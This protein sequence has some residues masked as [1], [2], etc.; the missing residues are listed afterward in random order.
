MDALE[1]LQQ[2]VSAARLVGEVP[3]PDVLDNLFKAALRA[4]DHG[5]LRPWRFL[6]ISGDA[7][8]ALG[9]LFLQAQRADVPE[10]TEIQC[11]RAQAKPLRA[12]LI[13][14]VVAT[15]TEHP[16]VPELEQLLS[17]GAAAQNLLVAAHAMGL[18]AMWRTG[19]MAYHDV[20]RQGLGLQANER[21]IGYLYIGEVQSKSRLL[22]TL[23]VADFVTA[24]PGNG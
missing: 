2:R 22:P 18:G 4:P 19:A 5:M 12:P 23:A 13:I 20:V 10:M 14:V 8:L 3:A 1:A 15:L 16:K 17:A 11:Q 6:T 21:L 9:E 24:W 7:R